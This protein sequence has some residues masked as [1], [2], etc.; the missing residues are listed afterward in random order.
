[1]RDGQQ[2]VGELDAPE[3]AHAVDQPG[4]GWAVEQHA[5]V[6][7]ERERHVGT[8]ER[9]DRHGFHGGA[10]LRRGGAQ[11]L[12]ARG[13]IVEQRAHRHRRPALTDRVLNPVHLPA[14]H[15]QPRA[16]APPRSVGGGGLELEAGYGRDRGQRLAAESECRHA[17]EIGG[18]ADLARRM[19]LQCERRVFPIHSCPV[20]ADAN[21]RLAA[22]LEL[23]AH[24]PRAGIERV[25]DQLFHHGAGTLDDFAGRD[26]IGDLCGEDLYARL[27]GRNGAHRGTISARSTQPR[28]PSLRRTSH[29]GP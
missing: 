1:M 20:V 29:Q 2:R 23:D 8:R 16:S 17:D 25:L 9:E 12:A 21:Q 13:R 6:T 11:E 14:H 4:R 22:V 7:G 28:T 5:L 3:C 27:G 26:L 24:S 18:R 15:A 10:R 19:T